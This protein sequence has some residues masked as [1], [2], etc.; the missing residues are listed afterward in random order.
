MWPKY[1]KKNTS[2]HLNSI[3]NL[4][5]TSIYKYFLKISQSLYKLIHFNNSDK[6]I[7]TPISISIIF[8]K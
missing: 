6:L 2:E 8:F 4:K 7:T 3:V 1:V 5:V